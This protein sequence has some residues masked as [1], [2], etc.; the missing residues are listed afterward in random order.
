MRQSSIE[1]EPF[2]CVLLVKWSSR[3]ISGVL[4]E[5]HGHEAG[6][7]QG[8]HPEGQVEKDTEVGQ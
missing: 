3:Q 7:G 8:Q 5:G 4:E 1:K 6:K 2:I